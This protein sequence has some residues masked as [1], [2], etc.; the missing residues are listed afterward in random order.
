[1]RGQAGC[2]CV[3]EG[4]GWR[5]SLS[6]VMAESSRW[7]SLEQIG[8]RTCSDKRC[9]L[10]DELKGMKIK[11]SITGKEGFKVMEW[12]PQGHW[13]NIKLLRET[14]LKGKSS[15]EIWGGGWVHHLLNVFRMNV[16]PGDVVEG[17][18]LEQTPL[19]GMS[20]AS[21]GRQII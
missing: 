17:E 19:S 12:T 15:K 4:G 5:V 8:V 10:S 14:E 11:Y 20:K 1:M 21:Y 9:M 16:G 3:W 7:C 13:E 6:W 18:V 2:V